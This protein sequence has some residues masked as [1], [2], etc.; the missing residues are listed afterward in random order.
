METSFEYNKL[1][2][3]K[4]ELNNFNDI[5]EFNLNKKMNFETLLKKINPQ[6][7]ITNKEYK[8]KLLKFF[9]F[10]KK[11]KMIKKILDLIN[12]NEEEYILN[13]LDILNKS[14]WIKN[15]KLE[16]I[17]HLFM[18]NI[19]PYIDNIIY[20]NDCLNIIDKIINNDIL[21]ERIASNFLSWIEIII[22]SI[23]EDISQFEIHEII[24][25]IKDFYEIIMVK[26]K[27]CGL[28]LLD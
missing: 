16:R 26:F 3:Q 25:I 22:I 10:I 1:L 24:Y 27:N 9:D 12:N 8:Y 4:C 6:H 19:F 28:E 14:D 17:V 7:K 13:L 15:E 2:F 23:S 5:Y 20:L 11:E 21:K 18:S